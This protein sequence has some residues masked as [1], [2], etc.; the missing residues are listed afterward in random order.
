MEQRQVLL[1]KIKTRATSVMKMNRKTNLLLLLIFFVCQNIFA[2]TTLF[3]LLPPDSTGVDFVNIIKDTKGLNVISYEYYYNGGGVAIGDIN[4][5]GLPDIFFTS[6]VNE[7]RLYLNQGNL[8]FKDVTAA[9]GVMAGGTYHTGTCMVDINND[10]WLDIYVCQSVAEAQYRK[11][12]LFENNK[13]GTF[14][15]R[16]AEYG[17]DDAGYSMAAYFNDLDNDGDLDL[18]VLN[19]PRNLDF[20]RAVHLAYNKNGVLEAVK[21]SIT[22]YE[23]DQ[24]YENVNGKYFN[25]TKEAGLETH[26]FGLSAV[27]QDFNGDGL[28]DIY[29]ANDYLKPDYLFINKGGGKFVNEFDKFFGHGSYSSMGSDYADINNDG[30]SDLITVDMLPEVNERQKQ[31]RGGNNYDEFEKVVKYGFGYQYVKNV[32]QL[33]NGNNTYSDISYFTGMAFSEWSWAVLT[34]D[35]DND[36]WKDVYIANGYMRDITD[37]D[38]VKFKMDSIKKELIKV[39]TDEEVVQLLEAIPQVKVL[40]SYFKNYGDL[41]FKREIKST[42]MDHFALSFGAAY[43]DLDNDGDLEIVVNNS[44]DYAFVYKNNARELQLGNSIRIKLNGSAKNIHGIGT[45]ITSHTAYLKDQTIVF[46]PMKGYLSSH[47]NTVLIGIENNSTADLTITWPD[48]KVQLLKNVSANKLTTINYADAMVAAH[49]SIITKT[50]FKDVTAATKVNYTYTENQ[51]IDFKL[52]PLLPHRFSQ[53][54]PCIC[55]ADFNGDKLEDFFVGGAKDKPA[56]IFYQNSTGGFAGSDQALFYTDKMYEDGACSAVDFDKDG[57]IDIIV[58]TGGNEYPNDKMKYPVRFYNNDGKGIFSKSTYS[59]RVFTSSNSISVADFNKDGNTDIFIGGRSV[60][61]HYGI[62]PN[63]FLLSIINDSLINIS[64]PQLTNAGMVTSSAWADM[65]NDGWSDLILTGEW[66]P[67]SV[68]YND[69]GVLKQTSSTI[70]NTN[71]WW[72][73]IITTDI[74]NDGDQDIVAGNLGMNTRYRGTIDRPVTMVVS[75]FD[76]NGSTDCI[77]NTYVKGQSYPIAIRDYV[78]DQM[79][80]LRK[81]FL[82]YKPYSAATLQDIFTADQ[83]AKATNFTANN[84]YSSVFFNDGN[85]AF[86]QMPLPNE[87]QFFPVNGIQVADINTDGISDLLL[88]GND[89]STEVETGRNDAGIGLAL[90]GK[91]NGTFTSMSVTQSGFFIPGDVK[92]LEKIIVGGKT[93]FVAGKNKDKLQFIKMAE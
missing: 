15:N 86:V 79:P 84:M 6:N 27:L 12:I 45:T 72:N 66:M 55:V 71:G 22:A 63:S 56:K 10:G 8:K 90:L 69:N 9:A 18:L 32:L 21:D 44:N 64:F 52:E 68:F 91:G 62:I 51:Y 77:I 1:M 75:D 85:A 57:D 26:A 53:M 43:A 93:V 59:F 54:G 38:Y 73:K 19:H 83:L 46:N 50:F 33:N 24:Y 28:T 48:G 61:G 70:E 41:K 36:G 58:T 13:D 20:A 14:T 78:L 3:T 2:Q 35:F 80:Y 11:N 65:N 23:S 5:D 4:N 76:D 39:K 74:D 87:A 82:R 81:K 88:A 16:A 47:D 40:K 92:C 89:Y 37:M 7:C 60:P 29:Q 17:I 42:G 25:K 31:L 30:L 67:I 49:D 34:A